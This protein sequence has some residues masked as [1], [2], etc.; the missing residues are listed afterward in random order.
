MGELTMPY[1]SDALWCIPLLIVL[2]AAL[3]HDW[4]RKAPPER[5]DH[6]G[7]EGGPLE[8]APGEPG[9]VWCADMAQ[10]MIRRDREHRRRLGYNDV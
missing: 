9:K 5:C 6:C 3:W 10:C 8:P 2:V 1:P 4:T 7:L